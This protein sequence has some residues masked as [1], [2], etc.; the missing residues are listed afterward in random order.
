M[1]SKTGWE[2]KQAAKS[3]RNQGLHLLGINHDH[4]DPLFHEFR[5]HVEGVAN[6]RYDF[7]GCVF[8]EGAREVYDRLMAEGRGR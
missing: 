7:S 3:Y 8:K 4:S 2:V 5:W 1:S 6:P